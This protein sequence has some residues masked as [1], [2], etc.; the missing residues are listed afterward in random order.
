MADS[1]KP[2]KIFGLIK[3]D[4]NDNPTPIITSGCNIAVESFSIYVERLLLD[5]AS[6]LPCRIKDIWNIFT[7]YMNVIVLIDQLNWYSLDSKVIMLPR[8][9]KEYE[10]KSVADIFE[11]GANKTP[12][13]VF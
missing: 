12:I 6:N 11:L 9:D 5:K 3:T 1:S 2:N 8:I 4:K 13:V 10:L 7:L